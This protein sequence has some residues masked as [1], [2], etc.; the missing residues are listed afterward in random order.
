MPTKVT[1]LVAKQIAQTLDHKVRITCIRDWSPIPTNGFQL[2]SGR[3]TLQT[4]CSE[5]VVVSG[6]SHAEKTSF[7]TLLLITAAS[8]DLETAKYVQ[9]LQQIHYFRLYTNTD[10]VG[11]EPAGALKKISSQLEPVPRTGPLW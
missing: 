4:W 6:P 11:V 10:V 7:A 8:K 9:E 3:R 5:I 2:N 1:R